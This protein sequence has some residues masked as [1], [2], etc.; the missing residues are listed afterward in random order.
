[1]IELNSW[2]IIVNMSAG[3]DYLSVSG[4]VFGHPNFP[5][6]H[7]IC[8]STFKSIDR[9]TRIATTVSGKQYH[10]G[11]F[12]PNGNART[13]EEAFNWIEENYKKCIMN[14]RSCHDRN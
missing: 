8:P 3:G 2:K 12:L 14:Q 6:G 7:H 1:M 5:H 4:R 10:L 13:E 11:E 9:K